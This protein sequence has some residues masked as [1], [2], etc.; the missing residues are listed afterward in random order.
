MLSPSHS[1][2]TTRPLPSP[3]STAA[4]RVA[5]MLDAPRALYCARGAAGGRPRSG[6]W[7][8]SASEVEAVDVALVENEGRA[9]QDLAAVD[10]LQFAQLA[11]LDRGGAGLERAVGD[12]T[13]DVDRRV[14]EVHGI[15]E[16]DRLHA[17]LVDVRLHGVGRREADDGDLSALLRLRDGF[18]TGGRGDAGHSK[19]SLEIAAVLV[20][21]RGGLIEGKDVVLLG[22]DRL[23]PL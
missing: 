12:R 15:P 21:E 5:V 22:L 17:A 2:T 9:Q 18:R 6:R 4:Q 20:D 3:R 1:A 13:Q 14:A 8:F 19:E 11:S 23:Q 7:P 16:H 10:D